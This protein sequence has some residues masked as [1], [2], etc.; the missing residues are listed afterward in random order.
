MNR[1]L[2]YN[3]KYRKYIQ[4]KWYS[5]FDNIVE[6]MNNTGMKESGYILS[7]VLQSD[8]WC[9]KKESFL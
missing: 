3:E 2:N 4:I 6:Q 5:L 9:N 1:C 7:S 8:L